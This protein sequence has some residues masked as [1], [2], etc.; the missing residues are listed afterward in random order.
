MVATVYTGAADHPPVSGSSGLYEACGFGVV[1]R[2]GTRSK[3]LGRV[4]ND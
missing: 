3:T 2:L 4:E 1:N